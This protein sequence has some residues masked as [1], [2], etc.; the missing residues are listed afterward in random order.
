[1]KP[2][3][4]S[5]HTWAVILAGGEGV[6]LRPLIRQLYGHDLPKQ[7]A[8][9]VGGR[10]LL[11][12]TLDRARLLAPPERTLVITMASHLRHLGRDLRHGTGPH[13]LA[14]PQDRG[15]GA[16]MLLAAHWIHARD[17]R[18]ALIS[19]PSDQL[20]QDEATFARHARVVVRFVE[21][22]PEW[23]VLLGAPPTDP[24]PDFGW[25]QPGERIGAAGYA[26]IFRVRHFFEKPSEEQAVSLRGSG[27]LWSTFVV[28]GSALALIEAGRECAPRL[29]ERLARALDF[30]GPDPARW[31]LGQAY[32]LAPSVNFSRS[33]LQMTAKP[34]AVAELP[35]VGWHDLGT[36]ARVQRLM[37]QL[38]LTPSW[39][40]TLLP[41][42]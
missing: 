36:P 24:D 33:V 29:D 31:A 28:A 34:L 30:Q 1:V 37:T 25:I 21:R 40:P 17:P 11:D 5:E 23:M 27:A 38:G 26:P 39:A 8:V 14:Q 22:Q 10:S 15:T 9:F 2:E 41:A 18:A 35:D 16:A 42:S 12:Q 20:V 7:Y 19:F 4:A 13:V 3:P 32:A 6:R